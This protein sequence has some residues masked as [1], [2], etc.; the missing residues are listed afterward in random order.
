MDPRFQ[1][2]GRLY[3]DA[4]VDRLQQSHVAVIG[5]GGVGSWTVEALARSG[6]GRLTLVD[7]DE[8]CISNTNR[9]L[10][11]LTHTVGQAKAEVLAERVRAIH[12][13]CEVRSDLAFFTPATAA[14]ILD[15]GFDHLVD[16]ID[17]PRNKVALILGCRERS[18]P[19]V[20]A[21]GAGG[22]RD[23]TAVRTADL[24]HTFGDGLLRR[25]RKVLRREHGFPAESNSPWGVPCVFSAEPPMFPD[26]QGGV[27][28][29]PTSDAP[30]A[31]TCVNGYGA[32]SFVTGTV[33]F[34]AAAQVIADLLRPI[35]GA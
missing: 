21:G 10:H 12:P 29:R 30:R 4:A 25:V 27:C 3:G 13:G 20:C 19:I 7:L 14:R 24:V 15:G 33:G 8:I 2:I 17:S 18:I 35:D 16:A 6:V 26:G 31:L 9:Q 11:T 28:A 34:A 1:G 23:P 5:V 32:A 22:R